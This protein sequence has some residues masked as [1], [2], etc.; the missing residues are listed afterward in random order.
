[1]TK[2][3]DDL[4]TWKPSEVKATPKWRDKFE[5]NFRKT[6]LTAALWKFDTDKAKV[7]LAA[8]M[9]TAESDQK[10]YD[11]LLSAFH[12]DVKGRMV[13]VMSMV[14]ALGDDKTATP[15]L[16]AQAT[17]YCK[18]LITDLADPF[19]AILAESAKALQGN[20]LDLMTEADIDG[21]A[22][23][24]AAVPVAP[25]KNLL[26]EYKASR[27]EFIDASNEITRTHTHKLKTF[28][29]RALDGLK[30]IQKLGG[31]ADKHRE[32]AKADLKGQIKECADF[33]DSAKAGSF[34]KPQ[35]QLLELQKLAEEVASSDKKGASD[36]IV[37]AGGKERV[38]A[39]LILSS[40]QYDEWKVQEKKID[41]LDV[42]CQKVK[43]D[44]AIAEMKKVK[45][46]AAKNKVAGQGFKANAAAIAKAWAETAPLRAT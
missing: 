3:A 12:D 25:L 21:A 23:K 16:E 6:T 7:D 11:K 22:K 38:A 35:N 1:M 27:K 15:E 44:T 20:R 4:K 26:K 13:N 30:M 43:N 31:L 14:K 29:E 39:Y 17:R 37:K 45:A 19:D 24:N 5:A 36:A 18:E 2:A 8:E 9:K 33:F 34:L 10:E 42:Y 28:R 40:K 46:L 41:L 32:E